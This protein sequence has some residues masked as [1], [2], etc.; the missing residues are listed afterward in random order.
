MKEQIIGGKN[1]LSAIS[2]RWDPIVSS[3]EYD[4]LYLGEI[5]CKNVISLEKMKKIQNK[6]MDF[7]FVLRK[8]YP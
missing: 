6:A 8:A 7:N 1:G 3:V 4:E 5:Q 2:I